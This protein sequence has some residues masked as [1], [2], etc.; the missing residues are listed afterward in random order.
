MSIEKFS[1]PTPIHFG[2]G[3]RKLVGSHLKNLGFKRPLI[4]TDKA[5]ADLPLMAEFIRHLDGLEVS[6]YAGV[7]GNPTASQVTAGGVAFKAHNADCVIGLGGGASLDVAKVV[8][9]AAT[10]DGPILEYAWD[11][12]KVRSITGTLPYF[13]A[14]PTT[15]GTG[16]EVG[17]SSVVSEDDTHQK[18]VI[19]H[20]KLLAQTVFADPEL[21]VGL[22]W[23]DH[24][25]H[26]HGRPDSQHRK[27]FVTSLPSLVRW[28]CLGRHSHWGCSIAHS[29][30]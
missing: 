15:S 28:H 5:M 25:S 29:C 14:L 10:H 9:L 13:V 19:F 26:W 2:V 27:L 6:V 4:V 30:A 23:Q 20:P 16:S 17:R 7:H 24:C 12:P 3:S 21:T 18:R 1:F 11:H 22:A 8:G